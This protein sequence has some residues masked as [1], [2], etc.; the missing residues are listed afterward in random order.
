MNKTEAQ[1]KFEAFLMIMDD[2]LGAL[3]DEAAKRDIQLDSSLGEMVRLR[4]GGTWHLPLNDEK[5][6]NF[7][8]PVIVGHTPIAGL[9]FAPLSVMRAY[10]LRRKPGTLRRAVEADIH[11][12]PVDL[13]G[14]IEP[15]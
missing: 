14:L 6:I 9:E 8:A 4:F 12:K 5:N 11:I 7:N 10:A 3:N 15:E 13:S 1:E 2:Q